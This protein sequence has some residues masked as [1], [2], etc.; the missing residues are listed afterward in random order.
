MPPSIH[1]SRFWLLVFAAAAAALWFL[2][3]IYFERG[4]LIG[5]AVSAAYSLAILVFARSEGVGARRNGWSWAE[6]GPAAFVVRG[7][8][9]GVTFLDVSV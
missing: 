7:S 9:A 4:T 8:K 5:T 3:L 1:V 6:G 2:A